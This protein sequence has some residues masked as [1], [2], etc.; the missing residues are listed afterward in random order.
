MNSFKR[1]F[2]LSI[3]SILFVGACTGDYADIPADGRNNGRDKSD[4]HYV[5]RDLALAKIKNKFID[6]HFGFRK[7][8]VEHYEL[9]EAAVD[10]R[11]DVASDVSARF[12]IFNFADN[13]GF[14]IVSADDRT[15]DV[16]AYSTE[17]HLN[18]F[19]AMENT[20]FGLFMEGAVDYF[21]SEI[22]AV[23]RFDSLKWVLPP[24]PIKPDLK[25]EEW[26]FIDT[27]P[28]HTVE[29]KEPMLSTAWGQYSP[30]NK[31]Y[32]A[33]DGS[34]A[35]AGCVPIAIAQI[36]A[37]YKSPDRINNQILD[38]DSILGFSD[39][40]ENAECAD[41][42][43]SLIREIGV[44]A[45]A[46]YGPTTSVATSQVIPAFISFGYNTN[47]FQPFDDSAAYLQLYYN[48]P[49]YIMGWGEKGGHGWVI[50]GYD[51]QIMTINYRGGTE[52]DKKEHIGR[53][54]FHCNWGWNGAYDGYF[55]YGAFRTYNN[56]TIIF[57]DITI[58]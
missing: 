6:S 14:A 18:M 10:T 19:D 46:I 13:G 12:H 22:A 45:G 27:I 31:Y 25:L 24:T 3:L 57:P 53:R 4:V 30:Y 44:V 51:W 33:L 1:R 52:P 8:D 55:L 9:Y 20:G 40:P 54:Y 35:V 56:G 21:D 47:G 16:Y 23:K 5:P 49:V 43:A 39:V 11:S 58:D 34:Q 7:F 26:A 37:F 17:G 41:A 50:D 36:M 32:F 48:K 2:V 38:W 28:F 29:Y 15:T 42:L